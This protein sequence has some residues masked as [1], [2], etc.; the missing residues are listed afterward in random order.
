MALASM[1]TNESE[2]HWLILIA[3][4]LSHDPLM[5]VQ[6]HISSTPDTNP[7]S[8]EHADVAKLLTLAI[9]EQG[10]GTRELLNRNTI[11][12]ILKQYSPDLGSAQRIFKRIV[13][14]PFCPECRNRRAVR[15]RKQGGQPLTLCSTCRGNPGARL[16]AKELLD[17]LTVEA[18]LLDAHPS[19]WSAQVLLSQATPSR[20][21]DPASLAT[22]YAVDPNRPYFIPDQSGQ[23]LGSWSAT[24][25]K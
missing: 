7:L 25:G 13:D 23:S 17:T 16:S 4:T 11:Q 3:T 21:A 8:V 14:R 1:T 24:T 5:L 12:D 9:S 20:D 18:K 10:K 6:Q 15:S 2:Q 22:F 19:S